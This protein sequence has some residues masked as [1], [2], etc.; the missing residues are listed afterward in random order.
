[1]DCRDCINTR[2]PINNTCL[3]EWL[4][5]TQNNK[6]S[7]Y[8]SVGQSIFNEGDLVR[9]IYIICSGKAKVLMDNDI[10][11]ERIIRVAGTGQVLGHRGFSETMVYPISAKT[12]IESE[13][14]YIS[15]EDFFK[16]IRSNNDL[17]IYMMMFFAD[18]LLKSEQLLRAAGMRTS[19]E[20]VANA[21]VRVINAFGYTDNKGKQIDLGLNLQ[22]LASFAAISYSTLSRVLTGFLQTG[23]LKKMEKKYYLVD[24]TMIEQLACMEIQ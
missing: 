9:G 4:Q 21:L 15:N 18:E 8:A 11:K 7:I 6:S 2:C 3:P 22:E 10:G 24:E 17:A 16:L 20:K 12:I 23:I 1:M 19:K 14:A 5:Y 13:I